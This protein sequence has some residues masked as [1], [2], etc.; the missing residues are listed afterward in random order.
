ME[1][2]KV[3]IIGAGP[4]GLSAAAECQKQGLNPLII[5]K[6][7]VVHSIYQYPTYLSFH[8]SADR[9]EIADIP[10]MTPNEKPTR[11]EGLNYYRTVASR[12]HLRIHMYEEVVQL[13][14]TAAGTFMMTTQHRTKGKQQYETEN[15]IIATGYFDHPKTLHIPGEDLPKVSHFYKE[16][17]PYY[18]MKVA[19]IG[20][21][22]SAVDAAIELER[23]GAEVTVIY[24]QEALSPSVKAWTKP[25]F[26]SLVAKDRINML[27]SAEVNEIKEESIIYSQNGKRVEMEND[28]V[29]AL[30]GYRPD[31]TFMT[32]LGIQIDQETGAP[33]FHEHS[34]ES[35]VEGAYIAG[36]IAAGENANVIF[37]ENG[38]EHGKPIAQHIASK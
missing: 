3:I 18:Q 1:K 8:S 33:F 37:I 38:R 2:E 28:F 5:E 14:K 4:C 17:H 22:N 30:T 29:F 31:R 16:A 11:H 23:A 26:E 25:V 12:L 19:I 32:Q 9:L 13:E 24:R 21:K 36:V 10:F 20:G 7:S 27:W 34:M 15:V 6:G 35:N